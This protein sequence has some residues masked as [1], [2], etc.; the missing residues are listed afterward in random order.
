MKYVRLCSFVLVSLC[1]S[2]RT[3]ERY[4]IELSDGFRTISWGSF[5]KLR[6]Q[7]KMVRSMTDYMHDKNDT[8]IPLKALSDETFNNVLHFVK[9]GKIEKEH[10]VLDC[11]YL[12]QAA[13]YLDMRALLDYSVECIGSYLQEYKYTLLSSSSMDVFTQEQEKLKKMWTLLRDHADLGK[14][15][16]GYL[17]GQQRLMGK[18]LSQVKVGWKDIGSFRLENI[19]EGSV[20]ARAMSPH[21]CKFAYAL[22]DGTLA[23]IAPVLKECV[24]AEQ[25]CTLQL[26][27]P[28]HALAWDSHS[29]YLAVA[30]NGHDGDASVLSIYD[31][32]NGRVIKTLPEILCDN[33]VKQIA[34]NT[35]GDY[36]ALIDGKELKLVSIENGFGFCEIP[37]LKCRS[38]S[39]DHAG[40]RIAC[41]GDDVAILHIKNNHVTRREISPSAQHVAWNSDDSLLIFSGQSHHT[42]QEGICLNVWDIASRRSIRTIHSGFQLADLLSVECNG[43]DSLVAT[44][45]DSIFI[46][47]KTST[48]IDLQENRESFEETVD[49][50]TVF[51][52]PYMFFEIK[53]DRLL[54]VDRIGKIKLADAHLF[55]NVKRY[56]EN[57]ISLE[58]MLFIMRNH[59]GKLSVN[60][61]TYAR[62]LCESITNKELARILA[63]MLGLEKEQ[64]V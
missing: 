49:V 29:R 5:H 26:N 12:A 58:Q 63:R 1:A 39:W 14:K 50:A 32:S 7:S 20:C 15:I 25:N 23:I 21:A 64:R 37:D 59:E 9:T 28:I 27:S 55:F 47:L 34:F 4:D 46:D 30:Q 11:F 6:R 40:K 22:Q 33:P 45:T 13:N 18:V 61:R 42:R 44:S 54:L 2:E 60:D 17:A 62:A 19:D 24:P 35:G 3:R 56:L 38:F 8:R 51:E 36:I 43:D 52:D 31:C 53:N 16:A 57:N 48:D 10:D 41:V